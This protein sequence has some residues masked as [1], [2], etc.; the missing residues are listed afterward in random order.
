[1][2]GIPNLVKVQEKYQSQ[3][4]IV[5]ASHCQDV[6]K[7]KVCALLRSKHVNY[8]VVSNGRVV[9][10]TSS[11]IP[12]AFLFDASGKCVKEGHP[13][14][15]TKTIDQ[16]MGTEPHWITR[17]K[18]LESASLVKITDGLKAGRSL[19]WA[20]EEVTKLEKKADPKTNKDEV[21]YLKEQITG[22]AEAMLAAAKS[23]EDSDAYVACVDY[24]DVKTA[25]KKTE[26]EKAADVRLGELKKDKAFQEEL[27]AGQIVAQLND[28]CSKLIATNGKYEL[29]YPANRDTAANI[30]AGAKKL[31][32]S[33]GETKAAKRCLDGLKEFGITP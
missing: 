32:K 19:G 10:D 18:K 30:M 24:T 28:L 31:K 22:E 12:H 23:A 14:E 3:G 11:G 7:D 16:L 4:L 29:D 1:V 20:L 26:Y 6:T 27:K 13:E 5:I 33:F 8:T 17:G 9:G 15:M 25:F 2:G 21:A